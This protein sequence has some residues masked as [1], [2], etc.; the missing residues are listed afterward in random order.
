MT[1]CRVG[2][3]VSS[4][5]VLGTLC[6]SFQSGNENLGFI[7]GMFFIGFTCANLDL[8]AP[9][10]KSVVDIFSPQQYLTRS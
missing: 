5:I 4:F 6:G 7:L 1:K 3:G 8:S 9:K 2:G 10:A